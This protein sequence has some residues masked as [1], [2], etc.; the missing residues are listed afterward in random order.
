MYADHF[1]QLYQELGRETN[2]A[3]CRFAHQGGWR[4]RI[5]DASRSDTG[6]GFNLA[7]VVRFSFATFVKILPPLGGEF[8]R[9]LTAQAILDNKAVP[10]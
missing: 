2:D 6:Q 4:K 7:A 3:L 9:S 1:C 8:R 5:L 10:W